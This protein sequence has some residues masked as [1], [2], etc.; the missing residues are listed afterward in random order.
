MDS[1]A[2]SETSR[3]KY[4]KTGGTFSLAPAA[5]SSKKTM[6][7]ERRQQGALPHKPLQKGRI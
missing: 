4:L 7:L 2:K 5:M 6:K 1:L 3:N